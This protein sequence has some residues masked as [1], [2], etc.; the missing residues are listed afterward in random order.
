LGTLPTNSRSSL[1]GIVLLIGVTVS[2]L[3]FFDF[4]ARFGGSVGMITPF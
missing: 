4:A 3:T 2:C 1:S